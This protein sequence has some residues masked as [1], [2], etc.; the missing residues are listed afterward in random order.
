MNKK[1]QPKEIDEKWQKVWQ[2]SQLYKTDLSRPNKYYVLAEFAYPSGDL[3]VGHWF[4]WAGADIFARFKRMQGFNVFFP[5]GFDSFGLPAEGAA[6]KRN[7]HPL[8]W[9]E[10]NIKRMKEQ[11]QA[12][13]SDGIWKRTQMS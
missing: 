8:D 13:K 2:D 9:T 4:T 3:H 10:S 1:Y 6:I 5:N 12:E 7:I 11:Y